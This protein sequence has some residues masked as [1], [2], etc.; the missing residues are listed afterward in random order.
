MNKQEIEG[1]VVAFA[2]AC[3]LAVLFVYVVNNI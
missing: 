2:M 3:V 1:Y